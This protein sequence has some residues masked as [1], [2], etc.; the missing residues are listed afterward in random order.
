MQ[1]MAEWLDNRQMIVLSKPLLTAD[2]FS[3][4]RK[5]SSPPFLF[6]CCPAKPAAKE[7]GYSPVSVDAAA[8]PVYGVMEAKKRIPF[9]PGPTVTPGTGCVSTGE[10]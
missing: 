6:F 10:S 4:E 9:L 2:R 8:F 7:A 3:G 1:R 5:G